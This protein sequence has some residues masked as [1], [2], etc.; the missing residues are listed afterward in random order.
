MNFVDLSTE[1]K[2][3]E[4]N[5]KQRFDRVF[6]HGRFIMGPEVMEL[7]ETLAA[8]AGARHCI[9]VSSGTDALL[10]SLM[11]LGIGPGDE[12]I[13][14]PFT[15][16][17]TAETIAL[18]GATPVFVDICPD[19]FNIDPGL[20]EAAVTAHTK[21][22][23]PVSLYGQCADFD[24]INQIAQ[25]HK[26][27]VIEDGA[28]SFGAGY[29]GKKSCALTEIGCTSFFPTKPLGGYGD[30]GACF[31]DDD[32]LA[33]IMRE[34]RVHGQERR[35][36]HSRVGVNGRLDTLQA[37][38]LLAK[39]EIFPEEIESRLE[40]GMRYSRLLKD[41]QVVTP[42]IKS[43]NKSVFAQ[44]TIK[45]ENREETQEYLKK[46]NIPTAV[47]YPVP[48][49]RQPAFEVKELSLP[50]A[51]EAAQKVMSLPM[52]PF[53]TKEE[54]LLVVEAVSSACAV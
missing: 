33:G 29:K 43:H 15:F 27:P 11:A 17:A 1:Y 2:K 25:K 24:E 39:F 37:A 20:I 44:Y 42:H 10:I 47:H 52:H 49:H 31:T 51:E 26:I 6:D 28:Q 54:Q 36:Y 30:G 19:T 34:I 23:I 4:K 40:I 14:T 22:I 46:Q 41:A 21:A 13:T 38:A 3:I 16:V 9:S 8:Y 45:V 12:V 50:V 18:L 5:L 32:N 7:E 53:L 35:Y 48:L